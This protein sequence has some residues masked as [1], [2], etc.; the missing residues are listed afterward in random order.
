[1]GPTYGL[2]FKIFSST[3]ETNLATSLGAKAAIYAISTT[4][5]SVSASLLDSSGGSALLA[6]SGATGFAA[7]PEP[8]A[9]SIANDTLHLSVAIT[10]GTAVVWYIQKP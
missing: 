6:V 4:D 10:T 8:L 2:F 3:G 9:V 7:F 1:M 5:A